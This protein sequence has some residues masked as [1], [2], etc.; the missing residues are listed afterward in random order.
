MQLNVY[1]K[2]TTL[3]RRSLFTR[4]N[5]HTALVTIASASRSRRYNA[6]IADVN[7]E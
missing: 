3:R 6:Q 2:V 1:E 7:M 5:V 4:S